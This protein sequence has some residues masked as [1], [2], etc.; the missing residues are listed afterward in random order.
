MSNHASFLPEC[1]AGLLERTGLPV[2]GAEVADKVLDPFGVPS[3]TLMNRW[4]E[5]EG[6]AI[7]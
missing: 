3:N 7:A 2:A 6:L 5:S 4:D 1:Q